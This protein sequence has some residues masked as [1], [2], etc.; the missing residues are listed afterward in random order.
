MKQQKGLPVICPGCGQSY[1]TTTEYYDRKKQANGA[2]CQLIEPYA[3]MG[4]AIYGDGATA[5]APEQGQRDTVSA[6][7]MECPG[8]CN[9][10]A[11]NGKLIVKEPSGKPHHVKIR[12]EKI[13]QLREHGY[14]YA[15]IAEI[16]KLSPSR[17][18]AI[19]KKEGK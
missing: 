17:V 1:H 15:K 14:S 4:W 2:M 9:P 10:L 7:L 5:Y 6:S 12:D 3:H 16:V 11:P 8:C 18:S 13:V 19:I